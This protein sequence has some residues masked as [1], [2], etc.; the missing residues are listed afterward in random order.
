MNYKLI[1]SNCFLIKAFLLY[2]DPI[3]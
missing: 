2:Y 3:S 1:M